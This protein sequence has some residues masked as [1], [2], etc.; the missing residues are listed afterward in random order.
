MRMQTLWRNR[1]KNEWIIEF[2]IS[3]VCSH[4]RRQ[5]WKLNRLE[6]IQPHQYITLS[7]RFCI[8]W[9]K[10]ANQKI[11]KSS[12]YAYIN[13]R[14]NFSWCVKCENICQLNLRVT[15][16]FGHDATPD[17]TASGRPEGRSLHHRHPVDANGTWHRR[18]EGAANCHTVADYQHG[19]AWRNAGQNTGAV[20][21]AAFHQRFDDN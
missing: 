1:R 14:L 18:G 19:G 17:H 6:R 20:F 12:R 5:S 10:D 21:P 16:L 11:W 2:R 13:H 3:F 8:R 9:C 4:A 15:V 7:I